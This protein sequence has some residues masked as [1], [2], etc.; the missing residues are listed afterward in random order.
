[1]DIST[2]QNH[3]INTSYYTYIIRY[4]LN[5]ANKIQKDMGIE[6]YANG[7]TPDVVRNNP[8][9]RLCI[10]KMDQAKVFAR[11]EVPT[12]K[13]LKPIHREYNKRYDM[14]QRIQINKRFGE[15]HTHLLSSFQNIVTFEQYNQT[16]TEYFSKFEV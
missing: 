13:L 5:K 7:L 4:W 15:V 10:S 3:H 1:M 11:K 12:A 9:Y 2:L 16:I 14:G 8:E 6:S